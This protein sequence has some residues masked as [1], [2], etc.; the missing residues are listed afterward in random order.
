MRISH[1]FSDP[2]RSNVEPGD[3]SLGK[4]AAVD[5]ERC[6]KASTGRA[7]EKSKAD[8]KRERVAELLPRA[9][10][11]PEGDG[12][13]LK[14]V[15]ARRGERIVPMASVRAL[16]NAVIAHYDKLCEQNPRF[17]TLLGPFPTQDRRNSFD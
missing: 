17:H 11:S 14:A 7:P 15:D 3:G 12:G 5:Y 2:Y 8:T 6:V 16:G 13:L 4:G 9:G 10:Y 1:R